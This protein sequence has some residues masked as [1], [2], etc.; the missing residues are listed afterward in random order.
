M[1]YISTPAVGGQDLILLI[2]VQNL[3]ESESIAYK[4]GLTCVMHGTSHLANTL[5]IVQQVLDQS[6]L[7]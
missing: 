1:T 2:Q 3:Y 4:Y 7:I 5:I 6:L